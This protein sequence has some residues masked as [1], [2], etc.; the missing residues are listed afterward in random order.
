MTQAAKGQ[1]PSMEEI[2]A[3]IR[4]IIADD[5]TAKSA[6]HAD[7][8]NGAEAAAPPRAAMLTARMASPARPASLPEPVRQQEEID[9]MLARLHAG[10]M[11]QAS[12]STDESPPDILDSGEESALEQAPAAAGGVRAV[13]V[14]SDS[15]RAVSAVEPR[16]LPSPA[17]EARRAPGENGDRGLLSPA[18]TAAVDTAFGT[19]ARTVLVQNGRTLEDL[20]QEM[21]RPML[22]TWLDSHLPS[23]VE[24]L[25]RTEIERVSRGRA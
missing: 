6:A 21:L 3:S 13:D 24:R 25:V 17:P 12:E 16:P 5:D 2:L 23:M 19:L 20:V 22:K 14:P 4:R 7:A 10:S 1:E 18:T 11:R 9:K 8:P 15:E